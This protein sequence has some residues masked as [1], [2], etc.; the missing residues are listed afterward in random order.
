VNEC[1]RQLRKGRAVR[2]REFS[3][4]CYCELDCGDLGVPR[5]RAR[6]ERAALSYIEARGHSMRASR[7]LLSTLR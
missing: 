4:Q 2:S 6:V 5:R 7:D 3:G 1:W